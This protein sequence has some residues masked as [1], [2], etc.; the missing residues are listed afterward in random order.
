MASG[1]LNEVEQLTGLDSL[2]IYIDSD[3]TVQNAVNVCL[4][5]NLPRPMDRVE[6]E[7]WVSR[8][9][10]GVPELNRRLKMLPFGLGSP[11]WVPCPSYQMSE[12]VHIRAVGE[13]GWPAVRDEI[14]AIANERMD[15]A[16]PPWEIH[17]V[18]GASA[19]PGMP[20]CGSVLVIKLHHSMSDGH[21]AMEITRVLLGPEQEPVQIAAPPNWFSLLRR[22]LADSMAQLRGYRSARRDW[23]TVAKEEQRAVESGEIKLP[24]QLRPRTRFNDYATGHRIVDMVQFNL[25]DVRRART[26]VEG[27]TVN[28][29]VLT[30]VSGAITAY[31]SEKEELPDASLAA[32]VPISVRGA[33]EG[34]SANQFLPMIV[35]LHTDVDSVVERMAQI[36][37]ASKNE[38]ARLS[39]SEAIGSLDAQSATPAMVW[40]AN[41]RIG[42]IRRWIAAK[43]G[44]ARS[45]FVPLANTVVS[46][47]AAEREPL[48][49]AGA[50]VVGLTAMPL[51]DDGL[52]LCHT[53]ASIGDVVSL[54]FAVDRESMEDTCRYAELLRAEFASIC[55][56]LT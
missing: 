49:F 11:Y 47:Y 18:T 31:L 6:L 12:H 1:E 10:R 26:L 3:R 23:M 29:V 17:L 13:P 46:N 32:M 30:V 21:L 38:K 52:L 19:I 37:A 45:P 54:T 7:Q 35:D 39:R 22:S 16:R 55:G 14:C 2:F 4:L 5:E 48:S 25:D 51:V 15:L 28:D 53:V 9:F 42:T 27:A 44:T 36:A 8:R 41:S 43:R 56:A 24:E 33:Y 50:P 40:W 20:H 34:S